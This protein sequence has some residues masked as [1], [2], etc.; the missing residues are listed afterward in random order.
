MSFPVYILDDETILFT[1]ED[2]NHVEFWEATVAKEIAKRLGV[3]IGE[4]INIPYCQ[5]RGRVVGENFY[6]GEE[7]SKVQLNRIAKAIGQEIRLVYDEHECTLE[8]DRTMYIGLF[9][10]PNRR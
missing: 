2:K 9:R 6:C 10:N 7:L 5:R 8:Y 3:H 1:K 4:V